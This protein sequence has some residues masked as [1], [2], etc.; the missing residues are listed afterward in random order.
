MMNDLV[1][2]LLFPALVIFTGIVAY[3]FW[4]RPILK[5]SPTFTRLYATEDTLLSAISAKLSGLKQKLTTIFVSVVG[6]AVVGHDSLTPL[7]AA[8]GIDPLAYSTQLLP[9]VPPLA[10]PMITLAVIWLIQ[11]FRNIADKQARANAVALLVAGHFLAAPA[12]GLT[13]NTTPSPFNFPDK[14]DV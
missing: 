14:K 11:Y 9:K 13:V 2:N 8:A 3:V 4:V 5:Q 12:P 1:S 10:W 6:I 7:L